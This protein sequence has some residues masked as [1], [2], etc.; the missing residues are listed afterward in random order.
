MR[1]ASDRLQAGDAVKPGEFYTNAKRERV[2]VIAVQRLRG[3]SRVLLGF[4]SGSLR[5]DRE[6][7]DLA[8]ARRMYPSLEKG[9]PA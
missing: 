2:K 9:G 1:K 4:W 3:R 7:F 8:D 5:G 6:W